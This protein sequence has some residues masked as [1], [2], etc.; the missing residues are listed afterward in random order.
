MI[1]GSFVV[2]W[3]CLQEMESFI[4]TLLLALCCWRPLEAQ[5][6]TAATNDPTHCICNTPNGVID[7]TSLGDPN[8]QPK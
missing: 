5:V 1:T 6:C 4:A 3:G 2:W 8:K 7:V